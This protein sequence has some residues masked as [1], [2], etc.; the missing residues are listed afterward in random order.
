MAPPKRSKSIRA[1][2]IFTLVN[3]VEFEIVWPHG[4]DGDLDEFITRI[5]LF[6]AKT[7]P[8]TFRAHIWRTESYRIQSTFPQ[9]PS[10][11]QPKDKPSDEEILVEWSANL[12]GDYRLFEAESA[13]SAMDLVAKD[14]RGLVDRMGQFDGTTRPV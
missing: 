12:L 9:D 5:E 8:K 13:E 11:G 10:T 3:T 4:P 1:G 2:Q 6:Q 7:N 14:V